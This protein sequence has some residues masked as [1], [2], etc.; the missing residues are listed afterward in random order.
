MEIRKDSEKQ[1]LVTCHTLFLCSPFQAFPHNRGC[2]KLEGLRNRQEKMLGKGEGPDVQHGPPAC[3]FM[4]GSPWSSR[5]E[6]S[7]LG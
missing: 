5:Q 2:Q 7:L 4:D 3:S 1:G 6:G